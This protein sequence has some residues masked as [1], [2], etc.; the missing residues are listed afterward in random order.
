[1]LCVLNNQQ[2]KEAA[3]PQSA[4]VILNMR[5]QTRYLLNVDILCHIILADVIPSRIQVSDPFIL[6][7]VYLSTTGLVIK[8]LLYWNCFGVSTLESSIHRCWYNLLVIC[9]QGYRSDLLLWP[10]QSFEKGEMTFSKY[11]FMVYYVVVIKIYL[12]IDYLL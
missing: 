3:L 10:H 11:V 6:A 7:L 1:M 12:F 8:S 4:F 5:R 9:R 2:K